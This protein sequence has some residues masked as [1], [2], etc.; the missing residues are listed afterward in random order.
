MFIARR[1]VSDTR[2]SAQSSAQNSAARVRAL[3]FDSPPAA[4]VAALRFDSS[5]AAQMP[6][7]RVSAA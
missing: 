3:R 5:L 6:V 2:Y 4:R 7:T 1:A